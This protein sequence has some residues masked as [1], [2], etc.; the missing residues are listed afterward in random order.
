MLGTSQLSKY[1]YPTS[2]R[3]ISKSPGPRLC[4]IAKGTLF[5][6]SIMIDNHVM[7]ANFCVAPFIN[8]IIGMLR[9]ASALDTGLHPRKARGELHFQTKCARW[10]ADARTH[11]LAI[12][13]VIWS[14]TCQEVGLFACLPARHGHAVCTTMLDAEACWTALSAEAAPREVYP[15]V[16]RSPIGRMVR[17]RR[18]RNPRFRGRLVRG[19]RL[20]HEM[21]MRGDKH[22]ERTSRI[23]PHLPSESQPLKLLRNP[24]VTVFG[25]LTE[26]LARTRIRSG[27]SRKLECTPA[28]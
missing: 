5:R 20:R 11:E 15:I 10:K 12:K 26:L 2:G 24:E 17:L 16:L 14:I 6:L 22:T 8:L 19:K 4:I 23:G 25:D 21:T 13:V 9:T 27:V 28:S 1:P 7:N 18:N 3:S